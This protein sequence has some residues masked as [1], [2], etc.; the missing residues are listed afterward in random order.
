MVWALRKWY[1]SLLGRRVKIHTDHRA[2]KFLSACA[3]DSSR[4]AR[5][6]TFLN[7]FDIEICHIPGKENVIAYTLSRRN[8]NNGYVKQEKSLKRIAAIAKPNDELDTATWCELIVRA[9]EECQTLHNFT[10]DDLNVYIR[11]E[12]VRIRE[13]S[14]EKIIVPE[15]VSWELIKKIHDYLLHYGTDKIADFASKYFKIKN[16]ERLVRDVVASCDTCQATKYYTR[17]TR[18]VEYFVLPERPGKVVSIDIFGP[19]PQTPKGFKYILVV[20]DQFSKLTKLYPMKSQKLDAIM[21]ALQLEHFPQLG[22]PE[23]ILSDNG[24]QFITNRWREFAENMGFTIRKTTP[25]NPQ[26]N[27]V[28]SYA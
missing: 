27:P 28:E 2:L 16:L 20:M 1:A 14:G 21:D 18:G 12:L 22:M 23:E 8:V 5:W 7:E 19:L 15:N 24:G 3:D 25:Y 10:R 13:T 11:D 26:S 4:I 17:P 6:I 9:Q